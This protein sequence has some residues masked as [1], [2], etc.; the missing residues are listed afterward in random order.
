M[1]PSLSMR[2]KNVTPA[3]DRVLV[4]RNELTEIVGNDSTVEGNGVRKWWRLK[5][6]KKPPLPSDYI[7][8]LMEPSKMNL[9][10]WCND[11]AH[12]AQRSA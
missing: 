4:Q 12:D 9:G 2:G 1:R 11:V 5:D 7:K 6:S 3:H 10:G 8:C